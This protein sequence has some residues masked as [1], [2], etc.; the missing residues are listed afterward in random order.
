[1]SETTH[2]ERNRDVILNR[3]KNYYE[4]DKELFRERAK[5]ISKKIIVRLKSNN[6]KISPI[7]MDFSRTNSVRLDK[8]NNYENQD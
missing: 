6:I 1:M 7:E 5:K 4:N 2:Y 8:S 3:A